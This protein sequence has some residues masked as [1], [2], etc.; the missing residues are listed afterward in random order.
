MSIRTAVIHTAAELTLSSADTTTGIVAYT[1]PSAHDATRVNTVSLD[2]QTG[3]THCDCRASEC[4]RSCWHVAT[5][6]E[7]W[8]QT[9]WAVGVQWLTDAQLVRSGSKA[10]KMVETYTA[11][12]GRSRLDDR[13]ALLIAR[14]EYRRRVRLG[15]LTTAATTPDP[16]AATP[17]P[18][19]LPAYVARQQRHDAAQRAYVAQV[20]GVAL[21]QAVATAPR[22][23]RDTLTEAR[24]IVAEWETLSHSDRHIDQH[25]DGRR[26][27]RKYLAAR[28]ILDRAGRPEPLAAYLAQRQAITLTQA[29]SAPLAA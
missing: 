7:A 8:A 16:D 4:G 27:E 18:V 21:R 24:A 22:V 5:V 11:R 15:L 9:M 2:T 25:V 13:T 10:R 19:S 14:A 23:T 20:Q 26:G 28:A 6:A 3:D 12:I 29:L 17:A 1:A